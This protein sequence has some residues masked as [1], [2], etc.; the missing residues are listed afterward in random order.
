MRAYII[1]R[2]ISGVVILFI[3]SIVTFLLLRVVAGDSADLLCGLAC[4][5]EGIEQFREKLG[6]NDPYFPISL[7]GEPP[8]VEFSRDNQYT[9]W[10]KDLLT[11]NLGSAAINQK[12]LIDTMQQRLPVTVELLIIT[13]IFTVAVGVPFGVISALYRNSFSD[14]IVRV[15]AVLGL[16]LPSFWVATLVIYFPSQ[17]WS[18]SPPFGGMISFVDDPWGNLRQFVPP[19]AVLALASAAGIMRLTR[20]SLLEVMRTD[21]IRTAR[22]KGLQDRTVISRHALKNSMIPVITVLGLQ[23]AGLLG[24]SVIIEFIFG[25]PG[26]GLLLYESLLRRD[27]QVVQSMTLYIGAAVILMNLLVDISYAWLDP[28]IRYS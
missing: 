9:T 19:A 28:R 2:L 20:S 27:Y 21:Y 16:A 14:Y 5:E 11:G 18:Y 15:T 24:G 8:F 17:W 23:V 25:L 10:I 22:S 6:L 4:D 7:T 26:I 1:R 12:P 3:L 13:V